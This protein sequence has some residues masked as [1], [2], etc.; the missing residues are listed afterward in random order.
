MAVFWVIASRFFTAQVWNLVRSVTT[1]LTTG[2]FLDSSMLVRYTRQEDALQLALQ[3]PLGVGWTGS[4]WVHGDFTQVAA[5][6]GLLA[7]AIFL[8]WYLA[9][10][11]RAFKTYR[12]YPEDRIFQAILT[13]F[14]LAGILLATEGME[15]LP[16]FAMPVWFVWGL[17]EAYLQQKNSIIS[18]SEG[19]QDAKIIRTVAHL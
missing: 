6:L 3:N 8:L 18:G 7:G 11:Y 2:Q 4:G 14:I 5:D 15:V 9:T 12:K 16:Q 13:S 10:L 1:P 19:E 17:M